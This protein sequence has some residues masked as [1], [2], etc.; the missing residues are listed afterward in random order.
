MALFESAAEILAFAV[1]KQVEATGQYAP[2]CADLFF[3]YGRA[4]LGN[5]ILKNSV[6]GE[7][8]EKAEKEMV[9]EEDVAGMDLLE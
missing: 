7:K 9:A 8:A 2:E 6:L 4:L 1:E 5:A 3:L